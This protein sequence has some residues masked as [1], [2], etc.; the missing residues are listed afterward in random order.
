MDADLRFTWAN[1]G[2]TSGQRRAQELPTHR[3]R[4]ELWAVY[5][6][7]RRAKESN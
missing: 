5:S 4:G 6:N 2:E 3:V 1:R 7:Q